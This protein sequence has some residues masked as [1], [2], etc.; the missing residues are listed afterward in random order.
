M[1]KLKLENLFSINEKE[2]LSKSELTNEANNLEKY[3][4]QFEE[5]NLGFHKIVDD[6][7]MIEDI[8]AYVEENKKNFKHFVVLGIGGSALGPICLQQ[9]LTHLFKT[10]ELF[11]LDNVDP[12]LISQLE[13]VIDYTQTLFIVITKSG[14]TTETISQYKYFRSKTDALNLPAT[15]HF[16]FIT[17][18]KVGLL[19][20]WGEEE[21]ITTFDIPENIGGRFSV[22][23]AVGLLPAALIDIKISN[24]IKGAREMRNLFLDRNSEKNLAFQ[25]AAVQYLLSKK[26]KS[27]NVLM[28]YSQKLVK[29]ADWYK[30]LLA[31]SIGKSETVGITPTSALGATDQH[32]QL[33][34][35]AEGPSDKLMIFIEVKD[36]KKHI[37][38]PSMFDRE[39]TFGEL[40]NIEKRA[41]EESLT[42]VNKA[43]ITI[44]IDKVSEESL[45]Q[46]IMLF[47][48]ATAI[49]GEMFE[50]DAFNQ[51]G[52][53]LSK[54]LTKKYLEK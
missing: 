28:P 38:I 27:I 11:V 37:A 34:L 33:Q 29:L 10:P 22:L 19:R 26:G 20:Q 51:P 36:H 49:L 15:K 43:N 31:E 47:E 35:Y 52:V 44:E 45:G 12:N 48:G 18:P 21:G 40:L 14:T 32:S 54:I 8:E 16:V 24:L 39:V 9:S 53:E 2:G 7:K 6:E 46:L 42:E 30:Q 5:K 50:I 41:T 1:L 25:L 23:T 3:L 17:D 4:A 13:E